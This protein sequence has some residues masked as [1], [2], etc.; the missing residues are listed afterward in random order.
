MRISYDKRINER[1]NELLR[2]GWKLQ[3][4]GKHKKLVSPNGRVKIPVPGTPGDK[5]T[6]ENWLH[7][8]RRTL[9]AKECNV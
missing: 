8:V 4:G 5:R 1:A 9:R 2:S 6:A 3:Y 7:Q